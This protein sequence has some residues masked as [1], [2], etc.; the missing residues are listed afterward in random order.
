MHFT[1]SHGFG[2]MHSMLQALPSPHEALHGVSGA[3][4]PLVESQY[5]PSSQTTPRQVTGM[6]PAM[7]LPSTQVWS[8]SQVTPAHGSRVFSQDAWHVPA[9]PQGSSFKQGRPDAV[10]ASIA[11][12]QSSVLQVNT[13]AGAAVVGNARFIFPAATVVVLGGADGSA[14]GDRA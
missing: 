12:G 3:H 11:G 8:S 14:A 5:S 13:G 4:L 7:H 1:S 10:E 9:S 2:G 6:Q